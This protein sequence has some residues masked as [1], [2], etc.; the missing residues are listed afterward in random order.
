MVGVLNYPL[1]RPSS[2]SLIEFS[3]QVFHLRSLS[4]D[5]GVHET[6]WYR[7]QTPSPVSSRNRRYDKG[8]RKGLTVLGVKGVDIY[9]FYCHGR[10]TRTTLSTLFHN[11]LSRVTTPQ[12]NDNSCTSTTLP[13]VETSISTAE[14][15]TETTD[16][17]PTISV[18]R[19]KETVT[20][21]ITPV[22]IDG[23]VRYQNS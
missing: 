22:I 23:G 20:V 17:R 5:R 19:I 10:R 21:Q 4:S 2:T 3:V 6:L 13:T 14:E 15:R 12:G 9:P 16:Y 7:V 1:P 11:L 8:L 18:Q